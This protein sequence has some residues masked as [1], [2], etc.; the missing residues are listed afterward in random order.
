MLDDSVFVF[1]SIS[2][3]TVLSKITYHALHLN[4]GLNKTS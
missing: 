2:K 3:H 4:Q 1:V